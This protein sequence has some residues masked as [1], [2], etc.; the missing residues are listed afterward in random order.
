MNNTVLL[1]LFTFV[2]SADLVIE[3][4]RTKTR[5]FDLCLRAF[6]VIAFA[7]LMR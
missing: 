4:A 6:M 1:I 2:L 7:H 3:I 5:P